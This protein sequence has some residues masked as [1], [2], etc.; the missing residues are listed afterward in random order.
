MKR[1]LLI[2]A[3]AGLG[4]AAETQA[5]TSAA[6]PAPLPDAELRRLDS[7]DELIQYATLRWLLCGPESALPALPVLRDVY[8]ALAIEAAEAEPDAAQTAA[9]AP[10]P[11]AA[12][13]RL[14]IVGLSMN[15]QKLVDGL[16]ESRDDADDQ[17]TGAQQKLAGY[18]R[19]RM[20]RQQMLRNYEQGVHPAID[21]LRALPLSPAEDQLL[22]LALVGQEIRQG[23]I[24]DAR[25]HLARVTAAAPKAAADDEQMPARTEIDGM[26]RDRLQALTEALAPLQQIS[27]VPDSQGWVL[28][29][30]SGR[31][32][33][34]RCGFSA[35]FEAMFGA[36]ELRAEVLRRADP[37][38][39]IAELLHK[40]WRG[41]VDG[42]RSSGLLLELLRKRHSSTQLQTALDDAVASVRNE[43]GTAGLLLLGQALPLPS[44]VIEG[45]AT[46]PNG[47]KERP[48]EMPELV[49]LV[50]ATDLYRQLGGSQAGTA[51]AD[52]N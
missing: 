46:V 5:S 29:K 9:Q 28:D 24:E 25:A 7:D 45:D 30:S 52:A 19:L 11:D 27:P 35:L 4:F 50:Q 49:A 40:E 1:L 31:F 48:L 3:L 34:G 13:T 18:W 33:R 44:T 43:N 20:D 2:A 16:I 21:F 23:R 14:V 42:G 8:R 26:L 36:G 17:D 38:A 32:L 47:T 10:E 37:N 51:S 22:E 12:F 15:P 39:A 41:L 6:C